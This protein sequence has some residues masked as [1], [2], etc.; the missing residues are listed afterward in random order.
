[1]KFNRNLTQNKLNKHAEGRLYQLFVQIDGQ[2]IYIYIY[3]IFMYSLHQYAQA[4]IPALWDICV[5]MQLSYE[6]KQVIESMFIISVIELMYSKALPSPG[7]LNTSSQGIQGILPFLVQ[8]S[9]Q[10]PPHSASGLGGLCRLPSVLL[11]NGHE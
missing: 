6:T 5:Y 3:C 7:L 8:N 4:Y 1:M 10:L 9:N 11:K 2:S